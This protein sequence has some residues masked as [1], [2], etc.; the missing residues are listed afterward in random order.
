MVKHQLKDQLPGGKY[1]KPNKEIISDLRHCPTTNIVSECNF[2]TYDQKMTQKPTLSDI[3]ACGV[4]MFNN[5]KSSDW[6][7]NKSKEEIK[8]LVQIVRSNKYGR[9]KKI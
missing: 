4:I 8:K 7:A 1:Y 2:A 5:S 9:I 3:A 6:L